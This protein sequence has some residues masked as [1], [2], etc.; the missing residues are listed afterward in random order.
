MARRTY[1]YAAAA[2]AIAS[3]TV[4]GQPEHRPYS[5]RFERPVV[6]TGAGPHR[7]VVDAALLAGAALF[8]EVQN[9]RAEPGVRAV[10]HGGLADLRLV[11]GAGREIGYLLVYNDPPARQWLSGDVVPIA[12]L[13]TAAKKTSGVELDVGA[14]RSV[15]AIR[16][17]GLP[18]PFL[19]PL[20]LEGSGD[21]QRWTLLAGEATLF[22]LPGEQMRQMSLSFTAGPYR[23]LR[24]TWD[25]THSARVPVPG[26][27]D[28]RLAGTAPSPP[29]LITALSVE[30]R[31][32]EP[33]RSRYR[34]RLPRAGLPISAL[35]F[36]V[37]GGHV[38]RTVTV[39][40]AR[41]AGAEVAPATIGRGTIARVTRSGATA[42]QLRVAVTPPRE[43]EL[44]VVIDDG[45]NPPLDLKGVAAEFAELP[46]IYFEA[47]GD[48]L[49][50][51]YGSSGEAAPS[52][53]LEA[54]RP[55]I[56][57][58]EVPDASWGEPRA[59]TSSRTAPATAMPETGPPI[60]T[61]F[62]FVRALAEGSPGLVAL[63]V[64]AAM[65][66]HSRGASSRFADVRIVDQQGRQVPYLV[67]RREEPLALDLQVRSYEPKA[68]ERRSE[69]RRRRS[70]YLVRLPYAGLPDV[71]LVLET[72][73]RVF[74]RT[75]QVG[76]DRPPDRH[77]RD[78]WFDVRAASSWQH[79]DESTPGPA[80]TLPDAS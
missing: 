64:D 20:V 62:R 16:L 13:E 60:D 14:V 54:V 68:R 24:V 22:D 74:Q 5:P 12:P 78:S 57:I 45:N 50:A 15:D 8:A 36:D 10:A 49:V 43:A 65:L 9:V 70:A 44:E 40:E 19:K 75:V 26:L 35:T 6:T 1:G 25:D 7:L 48:P 67:E 55:S 59:L 23:Y 76:V 34:V 28:V 61:E 73:A 66:A 33:G 72:S 32:S 58:A 30:R 31:A 17:E 52:Y 29:P 4:S 21:R 46:W 11:D 56:R 3:A 39:S 47:P 42:S 79:A 51:R 53:D 2:L 80:L 41:L 71:R 69:D 38:Y 77:R 63:T 27:V 37:G 18:A